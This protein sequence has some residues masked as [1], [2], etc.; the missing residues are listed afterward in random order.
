MDSLYL[1]YDAA[2]KQGRMVSDATF[3]AAL[4]A[5]CDNAHRTISPTT[6]LL[7]IVEISQVAP[8]PGETPWEQT[9]RRAVREIGNFREA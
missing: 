6:Y 3:H 4:I 5:A 7:S 8:L 1:T 9:I 2:R